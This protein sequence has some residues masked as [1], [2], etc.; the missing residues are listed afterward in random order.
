MERR[1]YSGT[2]APTTLSSGIDAS[3]L[4]IPVVSGAGFPSGTIGPF[5]IVIDRGLSTEEKVKCNTT[6]SNTITAA[7]GGR[8]ADGTTAS[9]HPLGATVEHVLTADD[10]DQLNQHAADVADDHEQ[11]A[12]ADGTRFP[13]TAHDLSGRHTFGAALGTPGTP[14]GIATASDAGAGTTPARWDHIHEFDGDIAAPWQTFTP[15]LTQSATVAKTVNHARYKV[16][17]TW[18]MCEVSVTI[19]V[20]TGTSGQPI[21]IGLPL[22][23]DSN[24]IGPLGTGFVFDTSASAWYPGIVVTGFGSGPTA[25]IMNSSGAYVGIS[26]PQLAVN[27]S[28]RINVAYTYY[29]E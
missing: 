8:G 11:Y 9:S 7:S 18:V 15:T 10:I 29:T 4:T 24:G 17:G 6:A 16:I 27:D 2:A 3:T 12:M 20:A 28:V 1:H 14:A 23:H 26:G 22:P 19:G 13:S 21:E 25:R 5:F